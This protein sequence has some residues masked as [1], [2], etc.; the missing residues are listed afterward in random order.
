[1]SIRYRLMDPG[2]VPACAAIIALHP[3]LAPRYGPTIRHLAPVWQSLLNSGA[4]I[5]AVFE[6][7][8][9]AETIMLGGGISLFVTDEFA[10]ELKTFPHFWMGPEIVRRV[11]AGR[12]PV[13]TN[14][15]VSEANSTSGLIVAALHS[16]I[17]PE[18]MASAEV[19]NTVHGAFMEQHRGYR[20][21]EVL[22]QGE[23]LTHVKGV[24]AVGLFVWNVGLGSYEPIDRVQ[25]EDLL[26]Q[27]HVL[28]VT[29]DLA[30]SM[31]GFWGA[32]AFQYHPPRFGF[33]RSQQRLLSC[34]LLGGPDNEIAEQLG[35]SLDF[36][37]KTWRA[38]Y[39]R[40]AAVESGLFPNSTLQ[41]GASV[42]RGKAKKQRL[43][44]Y[45]SNHPE[46]LRPVSLRLM[47]SF[48][49]CPGSI[50]SQL[51]KRSAGS[52][53]HRQT[54]YPRQRS[55][56]ECKPVRKTTGSEPPT[57]SPAAFCQI[58]KPEVSSPRTG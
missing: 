16:G 36:V 31:A 21:K 2:D 56:Q 19:C 42:E 38:I 29:R 25:P 8:H 40:V 12:S 58:G 49:A 34:G 11:H 30:C 22:V 10:D 46:E 53:R 41:N 32:A 37:R 51:L 57:H 28:G 14:R 18:H 45:V 55:K 13:L 27:P 4:C 44:A 24:S 20:L 35:I 52:A 43:L 26:R 39:D 50:S 5:C 54:S 33:N 1:M 17:L 48:Q 6:E 15:Q 9:G 3:S 7:R 47:Q 23:C